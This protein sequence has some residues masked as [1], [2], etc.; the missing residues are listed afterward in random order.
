VL[1][2]WPAWACRVQASE[3]KSFSRDLLIADLRQLA[4]MIEEV[5]PDPYINGGG[6]IAFARRLQETLASIPQEG[7]SRE[8]FYRHIRPFVAAV[9]D[10]HTWLRDPYSVDYGR[11]G[12]VP[13][14]FGVVEDEL[15][16]KATPK[17]HV[18]LIGARLVSME[19]VPFAEIVA[20][21]GQ[22]MG[23]ENEYL[24]LRNLAGTAVLYSR[25][26]LE[27]LLPEWHDRSKV[28]VVLRHRDGQEK[29]QVLTVPSRMRYPLEQ[30]ASKV[31]LPSRKKC[32]LLY[33]SPSPRD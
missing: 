10:A 2:L 33:T 30:P 27:P 11:P 1:I 20:R 13:L 6:K 15:Y 24:L 28:Q 21:Q 9:G 5:H 12:G 19:G 16:V 3:G 25:C 14:Y 7:M 17:E 4:G 23:A 26:S 22:A 29:E 8:A 31:K 32:C 18:G